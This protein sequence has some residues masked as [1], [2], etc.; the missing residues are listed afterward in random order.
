MVSRLNLLKLT[1]TRAKIYTP[2][3]TD[4]CCPN[5]FLEA[6]NLL[7]SDVLLSFPL[8]HVKVILLL[9]P[10]AWVRPILI[11][12]PG[13]TPQEGFLKF[14]PQNI[15]KTSLTSKTPKIPKT[16]RTSKTSNFLLASHPHYEARENTTARFCPN[17][18][19][20][21][22]NNLTNLNDA[23]NLKDLEDPTDINGLKDPKDP[24][25]PMDQDP[26]TPKTSISSGAYESNPFASASRMGA[27]HPHYEAR[28][29]TTARF[30]QNSSNC[31]IRNFSTLA[32]VSFHI[33]S[34]KPKR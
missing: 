31:G 19:Q 4:T 2:Q 12:R 15:K 3:F 25:D 11:M 34:P 6:D 30:C 16:P 18:I 10:P 14:H 33:S 1:I 7:S 32:D 5:V 29:N 13:K 8:E 17:F 22:Q 28:E 27:F 20:K 9:Q 24:K 23:K 21:S 26:K